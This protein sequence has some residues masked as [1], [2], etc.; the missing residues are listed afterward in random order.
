MIYAA[1]QSGQHAMQRQEP[2]Q[3]VGRSRMETIVPSASMAL[4]EHLPVSVIITDTGLNVIHTNL[5]AGHF[6]TSQSALQVQNGRLCTD[7]PTNTRHLKD[8]IARAVAD[9]DGKRS[10]VVTSLSDQ[11]SLRSLILRIFPIDQNW[12]GLDRKVQDSDIVAIMVEFGQISEAGARG[13]VDTFGL[14]RSEFEILKALAHG[15][16]PKEI[17]TQRGSEVAT[18]R[19]HIRNLRA[20]MNCRTDNEAIILFNRFARF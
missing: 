9:P 12:V 16:A 11:V 6:L 10:V 19:V 18:V 17:A 3:Q 1:R 14:S 8:Q 5:T 20:K 15:Y 7:D 2:T 13:L 4:V